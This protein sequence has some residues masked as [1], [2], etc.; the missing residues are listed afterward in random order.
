[1]KLTLDKPLMVLDDIKGIENI[2]RLSKNT[3]VKRVFFSSSSEVY[4]EPVEF[5]QNEFTTPLNSKLP[6]AIVKNIGEAYLKSFHHEH[7]LNYTIFRFFNTYGPKQGNQFVISKFLNAAL[8]NEDILI[9]GNGSQTRT[10]CY[11]DDNIDAT[12]ECLYK[13][14]FINDVV[15]MGSEKEI[16][17]LDLANL[18]KSLTGSSSRIIHVPPLKEGDMKRRQ[19]DNTKMKEL[20]PHDL[21]PLEAGIHKILKNW[22]KKD[23]PLTEIENS[24]ITREV[25]IEEMQEK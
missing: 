7:G 3:G 24:P 23:Y 9:N 11:I 21:L 19:P 18:I 13:D 5:P 4:G 22:T 2:L 17:V 1:V 12:I 15:N 6:Y 14:K 10:F 25:E 20:I 8:R 16:T